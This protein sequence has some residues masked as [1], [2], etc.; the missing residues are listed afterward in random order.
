MVEGVVEVP[1][2]LLVK[3]GHLGSWLQAIGIIVVLWIIFQLI[4]LAINRKRMKEIYKIK[5]DMIR[6]ERKIDKIIASG[7]NLK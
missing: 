6:I 3:L 1:L 5:S 7:K 2:D 4:S